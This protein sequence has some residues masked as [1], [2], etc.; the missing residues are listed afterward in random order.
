MMNGAVVPG[1]SCRST[2][3]EIAAI[4]ATALS[5]LAPGWKKTFTTA[6]PRS[7]ID[8]MCSMSL[9]VVV[10]PRSKLVTIRNDSSSADMPP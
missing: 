8:S 4:C 5:V 1:G 3:C 7:V 2:D 9:T 10:R 6:V